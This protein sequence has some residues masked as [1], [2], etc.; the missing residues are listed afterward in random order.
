MPTLTFNLLIYG[1]QGLL[2]YYPL[3]KSGPFFWFQSAVL[4]D[5]HTHAALLPR[6][7]LYHQEIIFLQHLE[8]LAP[9]QHSRVQTF[10]KNFHIL[11]LAV[12]MDC[13]SKY[14]ET[15]NREFILKKIPGS[16][17]RSVSTHLGSRSP[18]KSNW[19]LLGSHPT[20][21]KLSTKSVHDV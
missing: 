2:M 4:T 10:A 16:R 13:N 3:A 1:W 19:L 8:T 11:F 14:C 9:R 15:V 5:R 6:L 18:T 7:H 20:L 17:L 12:R 21:Q